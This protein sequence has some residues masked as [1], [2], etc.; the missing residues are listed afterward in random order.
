[1]VSGWTSAVVGSLSLPRENLRFVATMLALALQ[2]IEPNLRGVTALD[3]ALHK[4]WIGITG[5]GRAMVAACL[6]ANANREFPAEILRLAQPEEIAE[7]ITWGLS[8]RLCRRLT[9]LAPQMFS[10]TELLV[11]EGELVLLLDER[12]VPLATEVVEKDLKLLADHLGLNFVIT[13]R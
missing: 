9:G 13:K 12:A 11:R 1:M 7:A 8:I 10:N 5:S 6:L 2:Q 3:W 4:R